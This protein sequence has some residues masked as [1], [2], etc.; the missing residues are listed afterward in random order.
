MGFGTTSHLFPYIGD[1]C[2]HHP[3]YDRSYCSFVMK[4]YLLVMDILKNPYISPAQLTAGY[5]ISHRMVL[6]Y[7]FIIV[8]EMEQWDERFLC[9]VASFMVA[10][11]LAMSFWPHRSMSDI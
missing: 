4:H 11:D 9:V 8:K 2:P 3:I 10:T 6:I 7:Q 1:I 5:I